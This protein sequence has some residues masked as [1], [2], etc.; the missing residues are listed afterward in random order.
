MKSHFAHVKIS[1]GD[2]RAVAPGCQ[3]EVDFIQCHPELFQAARDIS[4][5][6]GNYSSSKRVYLLTLPPPFATQVVYK[7]YYGKAPWRFYLQK[8]LA[9][10]EYDN[11]EW[12]QQ[13]GIPVPERLCCGEKRCGP[14]L[15]EAFIA[16]RFVPGMT[17]GRE[18]MPAGSLRADTAERHEFC[19]KNLMHLAQAHGRHYFHYALHPRNILW[20]RQNRHAI[21]IDVARGRLQWDLYMPS[22]IIRDLYTFFWDMRLPREEVEELLRFYQAQPGGDRLGGQELNRR[23]HHFRRRQVHGITSVFDF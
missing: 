20:D 21:W 22:A 8:S 19:R 12:L 16:T 18:F 2:Y 9:R 7:I 11:Y 6:P 10:R 17:D 14:H 23:L 3:A 1:W 15:Q 5:V 4:T 13:F